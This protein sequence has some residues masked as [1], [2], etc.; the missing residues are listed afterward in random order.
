MCLPEYIFSIPS[1]LKNSIE[2]CISTTVF[3]DK[4]VG[5]ITVVTK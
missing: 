3:S 4:P 5:I 2:W 1:G